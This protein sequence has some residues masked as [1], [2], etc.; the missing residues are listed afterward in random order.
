[1]PTPLYVVYQ[2]H[3]HFSAGILTLIFAVYA[4]PCSPP[5][6]W[7]AGTPDQ[8][9]RRPVMAAALGFSA[10]SAVLFIFASSPGLALP[11]QGPVLG[12]AGR[13]IGTATA[14]LTEV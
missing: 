12:L 14:A 8:A 5:C 6:C 11:G 7:L 3:W 1:M 13:M 4:E 9:C 2:R 10:A